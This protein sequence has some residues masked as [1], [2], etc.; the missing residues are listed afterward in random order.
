MIPDDLLAILACPV[1]K[2]PITP[3]D[4]DALKCTG[5]ARVYPVHDGIP[6]LLASEA[7]QE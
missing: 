1:C 5:C 6:I 7:T 3:R 4:E 2:Q